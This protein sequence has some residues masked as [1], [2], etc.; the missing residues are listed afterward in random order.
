MLREAR[1]EVKGRTSRPEEHGTSWIGAAEPAV[2][3]RFP[4]ACGPGR[5][6]RPIDT[7]AELG[8]G[9]TTVIRRT[10]VSQRGSAAVHHKEQR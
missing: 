7:T 9:N 5:A 3:P 6:A 1:L 8:E 4:V 2:A 10:A